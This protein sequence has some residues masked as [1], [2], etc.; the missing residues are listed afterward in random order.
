MNSSRILTVVQLNTYI[1]TLLDTDEHLNNIYVVGEISNFTDHYRT[2]HY[3]FTLKDESAI[4]KCVMF[5]GANSRLR[6]KPENGMKVVVRGRVSVYERD[7]QY[8]VYADDMQPDGLGALNLAFEQLK[9]RLEA[10]GLFNAEHKQLIPRYPSVIGV[11]T[12]PTGA[13]VRDITNV[14]SRRFPAAVIVFCPVQVQGDSAAGQIVD[15]ICR[16]NTG[17][18]ADVL[19][20]GRGGGSIEELWAFNE[21]RVAR[22][23]FESRIPIISA[24]GHETDF[25]ICDFVS[26]LRAP[27]PSAAAELAVPDAFEQKTVLSSLKYRMVKAVS[28]YI[29]ASRRE[30]DRLK[31]S[32]GLS[33]PVGSIENHRLRLDSQISAMQFAVTDKLTREQNRLSVLA[34][35]LDALSPLKVLGRGYAMAFCNGQL[36]KEAQYAS[37]GDS[38]DVRLYSG[39]LSCRV[40]SVNPSVILSESGVENE[41]ADV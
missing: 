26:D 25:T 32:Q 14:L 15:A 22:A 33:S 37:I 2:G 36:L 40:E 11:I 8:Q 34:G 28:L 17:P 3:Y 10:E 16:F 1:K 24:V 31:S 9:K 39:S 29:E 38:L 41:K 5:R 30:L 4:V 20:V 21:E 27:T 19:I 12:S 6:F 18:Y 13:A 35:K 7:G 23:V